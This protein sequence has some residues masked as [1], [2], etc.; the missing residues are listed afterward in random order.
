MKITIP[1]NA[2]TFGAEEKQAV[3]A[4]IDSGSYTMGER[5]QSFERR[6]AEYVGSKYAVMVNSGSSANLLA[7]SALVDPLCP[8]LGRRRR[9]ERGREIIVP[10]LTWSTTIW[11]VIQMG[12]VPVF[13][14]CDP[15]TLQMRPEDIEA[16]VGPE[17]RAIVIVHVLGGAADIAA[18]KDIADRNNL[19]LVE[20]T[21]E[22]L[23]VRWQ[24]KYV[25]AF[26][27]FGTF[28]FFFS[29]HI[30]TIEGGML[31]T[32][33]HDLAELARAQRAH[34]WI[35]HMDDRDKWAEKYPEIDSRYL[36]ITTGYNVR[37]TEISGAIGLVQIGRVE[38]FNESRRNL[39]GRIDRG[40]APSV[41]RGDLRLVRYPQE[42]APAP[43]GYVVRCRNKATRNKFGA[44]LEANGIETRP[45]ICGNMARQPAMTHFP[46]RVCG[47][48]AGA[49]E[50]MDCGLYWGVHPTM[51]NAE[52]DY[53]VGAVRGFFE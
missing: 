24:D 46:H 14:D 42:C 17:T 27:D 47:S 23:G 19:W 41:S 10:A 44:H 36:F 39:A 18:I 7:L 53:V 32:N 31:V 8:T 34:G 1:L 15:D 28:S 38:D 9:I 16:A 22:S 2:D 26:G 30:S 51:T 45:V 33:D 6:F 35:R 40:L 3:Q 25:G 11:P 21:C 29:H 52:I 13:V 37:P 48:L 49:D 5:C 12:C 20:D 43:F 50:M 4:V